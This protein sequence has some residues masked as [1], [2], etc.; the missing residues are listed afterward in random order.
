MSLPANWTSVVTAYSPQLFS[1][2]FGSVATVVY[3]NELQEDE[4]EEETT[5]VVDESQLLLPWNEPH[6]NVFVTHVVASTMIWARLIGAEHS[7]RWDELMATIETKMSEP[8]HPKTVEGKPEVGTVYLLNNDIGWF[9]VRCQEVDAEGRQMLGFYVD[10]GNEEWLD[11]NT[12]FVC[13]KEFLSVPEQAVLFSLFGMDA[14]EGNPYAK[15]ILERQ[16]MER[17]F[18]AELVTREEEYEEE[19]KIKVVLYDTSGA[20]DVNLVEQLHERICEAGRPPQLNAVAPTQ[21]KVTYV[22]D[23]GD[24]ICQV[25]NTGFEYVQRLVQTVVQ[26]EDSMIHCRGLKENLASGDAATRYL[27]FDRENDSWYR[28]VLKV[29]HPQTARHQMYCLDFG[30]QVQVAE[31]D[32]YH[33]E[34]LC[35]ALSRFPAMALRLELYDIPKMNARIISRIRDLL[36]LQS[37]GMVKVLFGAGLDGIPR[38]NFYKRFDSN[39]LIV[40]IND[41]LRLEHDLELSFAK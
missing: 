30:H 17:A 13:D 32:I 7:E 21:V 28:A 25:P 15:P 36:E 29:R 18:V 12:V 40:C 3:A 11:V 39:H 19:T 41:T 4:E 16:L 27:V 14:M 23:R 20:D 31:A 8:A 33:L 37:M 35:K 1:I 24:V 2:D 6:W 22:S 9:R 34:P 38:V 10:Q 5:E 26:K